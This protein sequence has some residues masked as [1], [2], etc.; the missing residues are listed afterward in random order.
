MSLFNSGFLWKPN[1]RVER[2][3]RSVDGVHFWY[4]DP[5]TGDWVPSERS[6]VGLMMDDCGGRPATC[7]HEWPH[8]PMDCFED[9]FYINT[10]NTFIHIAARS[11]RF[12]WTED[13]IGR[14]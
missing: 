11:A 9:T 1:Y 10:W 3:G 5:P 14:P 8:V 4:V 12:D 13:A 7:K 2:R 6:H